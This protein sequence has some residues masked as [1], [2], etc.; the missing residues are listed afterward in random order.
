MVKQKKGELEKVWG[1]VDW[2]GKRLKE[3]RELRGMTGEEVAEKMGVKY[4]R[5]YDSESAR[6]DIRAST[7]FRMLDVLGVEFDHFAKTAP[8]RG[9]WRGTDTPAARKERRVRMRQASEDSRRVKI[10]KKPSS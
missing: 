3:L 9:A 7:I 2:V 5:I 10:K 8:R 4:T 6:N 1:A